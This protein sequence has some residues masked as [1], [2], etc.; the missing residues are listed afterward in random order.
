MSLESLNPEKMSRNPSSLNIDIF[1]DFDLF[2]DCEEE[3]DLDQKDVIFEFLSDLYIEM[4]QETILASNKDIYKN[5][6]I[7]ERHSYIN[8]QRDENFDINMAGF[9]EMISVIE[10][11]PYQFSF[12]TG[13]NN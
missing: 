11:S 6:D 2:Q 9:M 5:V 10:Q 4:H 8:K 7:N 13:F 1:E 3:C 12:S